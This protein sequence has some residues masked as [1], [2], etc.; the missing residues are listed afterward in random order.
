MLRLGE[1]FKATFPRDHSGRPLE[2]LPLM[3]EVDSYQNTPL[4]VSIA[5]SQLAE[6]WTIWAGGRFGQ[7]IICGTT[8]IQ[9]VGIYPYYQTGQVLGFLG[10]LKGAAEYE[11]LTA[12]TGAATTGMD[13]Q[14]TAHALIAALVVLGNIAYWSQRRARSG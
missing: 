8:A 13:A 10:G 12:Q 3:R 9:A 7:K 5:S 14:T 11:R 1:S 2:Q 4:L 6:Y